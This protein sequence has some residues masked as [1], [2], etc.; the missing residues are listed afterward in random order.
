LA[1][2]ERT[3]GGTIGS[4]SSEYLPT[5]GHRSELGSASLS[6]RLA[7]SANKL[8]RRCRTLSVAISAASRRLR[9]GSGLRAERHGCGT[10]PGRLQTT[11]RRRASARIDVRGATS[12]CINLIQIYENHNRAP[13]VELEN[14]LVRRPQLPRVVVR[15]TACSA[16][17]RR[18]A[19]GHVSNRQ[20]DAASRSSGVIRPL[21]VLSPKI[22]HRLSSSKRARTSH[23]NAARLPRREATSC[24]AGQQNVLY[25]A[26]VALI[27]GSDLPACLQAIVY[28]DSRFQPLPVP[29]ALVLS[30]A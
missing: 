17:R 8:G 30:R 19:Y 27:R 24:R 18:S 29:M 16:S 26:Y 1:G 14:G 4:I 23:P 22:P 6:P 2:H 25:V 12:Q 20:A 21:T 13:I 11:L 5:E 10:K 7:P 15:M 28:R 9:G 3:T